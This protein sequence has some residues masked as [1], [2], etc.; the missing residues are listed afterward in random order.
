MTIR[1]SNQRSA[2][3]GKR[4]RKA[5]TLTMASNMAQSKE[6][7]SPWKALYSLS[8]KYRRS[9][10]DLRTFFLTRMSPRNSFFL[11]PPFFCCDRW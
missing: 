4:Q 6:R 9:I 3:I 1:D 7:L 2:V 11:L 5:G 10:S 8:T